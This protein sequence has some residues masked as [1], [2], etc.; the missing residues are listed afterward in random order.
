MR[1]CEL[2]LS[3]ESRSS[4]TEAHPSQEFPYALPTLAHRVSGRPRANRTILYILADPTRLMT[5]SDSEDVLAI[6]S[7]S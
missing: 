3:G 5:S 6:V 7:S 2:P 1:A 4:T